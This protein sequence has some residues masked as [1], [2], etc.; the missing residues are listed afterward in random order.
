MRIQNRPQTA[1]KVQEHCQCQ[2]DRNKDA[3]SD[4][5]L[6]EKQDEADKEKVKSH[7]QGDW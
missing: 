7:M 6:E 1:A 4:V 3:N 5:V 2:Q